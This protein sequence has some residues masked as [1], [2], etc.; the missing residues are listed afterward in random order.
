MQKGLYQHFKSVADAVDIPIILYNI[1]GRTARNIETETVAK[2]AQ[3]CKNI[4]EM[5]LDAVQN[6]NKPLTKDRLFG[7]HASLFPAG[8]SG[9]ENSYLSR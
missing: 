2:L 5:M 1:E 8:R 4:V 7:W 9:S 6:F 3:D